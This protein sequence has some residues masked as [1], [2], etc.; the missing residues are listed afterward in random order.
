MESLLKTMEETGADFTNSFR[1]LSRMPLPGTEG[2]ESR[3]EEVLNYLLT[4]CSTVE[5]MKKSCSPRMDPRC[6]WGGVGGGGGGGGVSL[7][8]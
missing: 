7:A 8:E 4:Q 6:V 1:C 2:F 5:E 3:R